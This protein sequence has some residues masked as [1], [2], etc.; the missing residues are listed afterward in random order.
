MTDDGTAPSEKKNRD[1]N[2]HQ[3]Q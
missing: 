3:N 1:V 2:Q